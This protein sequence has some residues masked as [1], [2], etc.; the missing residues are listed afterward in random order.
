MSIADDGEGWI[1]D[2]PGSFDPPWRLRVYRQSA[3]PLA[4]AKIIAPRLG[5]TLTAARDLVIAREYIELVADTT[6]LAN[7]LILAFEATGAGVGITNR[8]DD[9][10]PR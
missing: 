7:E 3:S 1:L 8:F 2:G 4:I 10:A 9:D 5:L 6:E